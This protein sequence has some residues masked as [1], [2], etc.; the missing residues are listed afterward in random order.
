MK[1][2][3]VQIDQILANLTINARD[4]IAGVGSISI[5]TSTVTTVH[6]F[7]EDLGYTVLVAAHSAKALSLA[8]EH[9]GE[10][11]LL[12]TDVIMPGMSGRDLADRLSELRPTIKRLFISGFTADVIAQRGILDDGVDFLSKPFGRDALASTVREVLDA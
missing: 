4:A 11:H 12:I 2:D 5:E 3:P 10:I 1:I 7:L 6:M 9:S 8:A